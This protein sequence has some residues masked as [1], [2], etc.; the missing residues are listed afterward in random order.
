[1]LAF[2]VILAIAVAAGDRGVAYLVATLS[3][4]AAALCVL[5]TGVFR[6]RRNANEGTGPGEP[7][8][9]IRPRVIL[10]GDQGIDFRTRLRRNRYQCAASGENGPSRFTSDPREGQWRA[11]RGLDETRRGQSSWSRSAAL[12]PIASSRDEDTPTKKGPR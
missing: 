4:L 7:V 10:A 1:M 9:A 8:A 11:G 5:A 6:A 2:L 3:A 12:E